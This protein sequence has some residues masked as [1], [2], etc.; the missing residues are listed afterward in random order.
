MHSKYCKTLGICFGYQILANYKINNNVIPC[1]AGSQAGILSSFLLPLKNHPFQQCN[2]IKLCYTYGNMVCKLPP[3]AIP[4]VQS[5]NILYQSIA[6]LNP[7]KDYYT[8]A[9]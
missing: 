7:N 6:Y 5:T 1:P 4:L 8:F 2:T 9:F 3:N